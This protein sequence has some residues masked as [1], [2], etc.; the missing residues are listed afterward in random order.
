MG[1]ESRRE[2]EGEEVEEG[3]EEEWR[4]TPHIWI[5]GLGVASSPTAP[6]I[7]TCLFIHRPV[8]LLSIQQSALSVSI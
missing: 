7:L 4:S 1:E 6:P 8:I 2:E 5:G 3:K